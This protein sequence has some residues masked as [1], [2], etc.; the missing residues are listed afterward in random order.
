[1]QPSH[2]R[3]LL[4][5]LLDIT[6]AALVTTLVSAPASFRDITSYLVMMLQKRS[7][8]KAAQNT[9]LR[10]SVSSHVVAG[11]ST[12]GHVR[13]NSP[14]ESRLDESSALSCRS[15]TLRVTRET[16]DHGDELLPLPSWG[17]N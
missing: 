17:N 12:G 2:G 9:R 5:L 4:M 8:K 1:M 6:G 14:K 7:I 3:R 15:S 16:R 11:C 10:S 13:K